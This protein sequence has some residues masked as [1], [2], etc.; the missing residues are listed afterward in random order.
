VHKQL[1][2]IHPSP[3]SLAN[4]GAGIQG[5]ICLACGTIKMLPI[6]ALIRSTHS[7]KAWLIWVER[8][9]RV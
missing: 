9:E 3:L 5:S 2:G 4:R 8:S 7:L 6:R 1:L